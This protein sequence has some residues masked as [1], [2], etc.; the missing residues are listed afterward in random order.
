MSWLI[1]CLVGASLALSAGLGVLIGL[2]ELRRRDREAQRIREYAEHW[3]M[4]ADSLDSYL[5]AFMRTKEQGRLRWQSRR[6][7]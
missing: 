4:H 1:W 3:S 7:Q 6:D 2:L 5:R